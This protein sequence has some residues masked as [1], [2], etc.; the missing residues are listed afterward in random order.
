VKAEQF[1]NAVNNVNRRRESFAEKK[2]CRSEDYQQKQLEE[3]RKYVIRLIINN[4]KH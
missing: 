3:K 2:F 1:L 4:K